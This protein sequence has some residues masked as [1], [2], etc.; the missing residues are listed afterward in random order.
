MA[1]GIS[2]GEIAIGCIRWPIPKTPL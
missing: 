1:T 2:R